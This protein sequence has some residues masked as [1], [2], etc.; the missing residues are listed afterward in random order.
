MSADKDR[1]PALPERH[2]GKGV[3]LVAI[4]GILVVL[5][6][7][8]VFL[9]LNTPEETPQSPDLVTSRSDEAAGGDFTFPLLETPR[10]LPTIGF[11]DSEG[12]ET[13][14]GAFEGRTVL[15]NIWATWCTP[16]REEMPALDRLQARLGGTDFEVVA[17]AID[18]EGMPAV[19]AFYE[20]LGLEA[21]RIYVDPTGRAGRELGVFGI[22]TTLLIG[23]S[24]RELG[25]LVGPADWDSEE[26]VSFTAQMLLLATGGACD[27]PMGQRGNSMAQP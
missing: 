11:L 6:G 27:C 18:R 1:A 3:L 10:A 12:R 5:A 19:R 17:L 20:E 22:P 13:T 15:L 9:V 8:T 26:A 7:G 21:L 25:R 16:C 2:I 24:G 4:A 23:P 14:F